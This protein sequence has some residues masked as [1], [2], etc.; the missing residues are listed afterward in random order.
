MTPK[1]SAEELMSLKLE[2]LADV[3]EKLQLMRHHGQGLLKKRSFRTSFPILLYLAHQLKG[4]GGS[5]GFPEI[6]ELAQKVGE[7]LNGYLD[8][9]TAQRPKP[10]ELSA[11]VLSSVAA[12]EEAADA[13]E[14]ELRSGIAASA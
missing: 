13:A 1:V 5:L 7:E 4:S 6:T 11:S 8:D 9:D 2:Y 14:Q 10:Q 12:L 3:R